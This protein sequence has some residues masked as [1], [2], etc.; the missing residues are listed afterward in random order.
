MEGTECV[1][2][3]M[4]VGIGGSAGS[5]EPIESFISNMPAKSGLAFAVALH[6]AADQAE[7]M[8]D[9]LGRMTSMPVRCIDENGAFTPD[10]ISLVRFAGDQNGSPTRIDRFFTRLAERHGNSAIAIILSGSGD[11]GTAGALRVAK[12]G[13]SVLVQA[14]DSAPYPEM[15]RNVLQFCPEAQPLVPEKL[16]ARVL[17]L[18]RVVPI[19]SADDEFTDQILA[20]LRVVKSR[21][22]NDFSA[23]KPS[24]ALRR[25]DRRMKANNFNDLNLYISFLE[26]N[27]EEAQ[28]LSQ[29]FCIGVT[30]FFRDP[31]AFE[32]LRRDIIPNMFAD[33]LPNDP[34]RIWDTCCSTGEETYSLAMLLQQYIE[35]HGPDATAKLF[36]TDLDEL[37][38]ARARSGIYPESSVSEIGE[39]RLKKF[40]TKLTSGYQV[41]KSLRE[42]IIFAHHNLIKDPP[43]SRLDMVVC[44]NFFI[45]LKPELQ[46]R[47]I[48]L[49]HSMLRPGG[50][51]FMGN[52][53]SLGS[54]T[55]LF[56]PIDKRWRIFQRREA[57]RQAIEGIPVS[58]HFQILSRA[59]Q[60]TF[61][62][63]V[64]EPS[65]GEMAR[66][67]LVDRFAPPAIVVN[68]RYEVVHIA[69]PVSHILEVPT[70]D[71][72]RDLFRMVREEVK[73]ALRA[74]IHKA[75]K[76]NERVVFRGHNMMVGGQL[77]E[78]EVSAEPLESKG[79][80]PRMA[81]VTLQPML[82]VSRIGKEKAENGEASDETRKDELI[83][84]LEEQLRISQEELNATIEQLANSND[85]M[86]STNE[87]LMSVNEEFQSTNEELETSKEELQTLNE[88]LITLNTELQRKVEALD[89]ANNDIEN[90]LNGTQIATLFLDCALRVKRF[91][92]TA[93]E[94]FNLIAADIGR[95]FEH[96]TGSISHVNISEDA[97][98]VI[99]TDSPIERA[100]TNAA[101]DRHYLMRL[102]PYRTSNGKVEGVVATFVDFTER[103]HMEDS[104][105]ELAQ[106]LDL[107]PVLVRDL[108]GRIILWNT[109]ARLLYGFS[110]DEALGQVS[111]QLLGT[112]FPEP[113]ENIRKQLH[114]Q[115]GWSGELI[116][117]GRN[118]RPVAVL[119]QWVLYRDLEGRPVRVLEIN[120]DVSELKRLEEQYRTLF[121][122]MADGMVVLQRREDEVKG[123]AG[124]KIQ[125]VNASFERT[126]GMRTDQILGKS[127]GELLPG[128]E[129]ACGEVFKKLLENNE[130]GR[131]AY[132]NQQTAKH[133]E[134]SVFQPLAGQLAMIFHDRTK[135][136]LA[137]AAQGKMEHEL[138][139]AQKMESLG[140]LAGGIAHDFNNILSVILGYA[141]L[142]KS[143]G[144]QDEEYAKWIN[145]ILV[146]ANNAKD[147]IRQI[148]VFSRQSTA[149][150]KPFRIGP[151]ID[152][153]IA[154]LRPSIRQTITVEVQVDE[155]CGAILGNPAQVRRVVV[156]LCTNA[157]HSMEETGGCLRVEVK[158]VA[159]TSHRAMLPGEYIEVAVNDTGVGMQAEVVEKI[160]DPYFTTKEI[161]RGSGMGLAIAHGIVKAHGGGIV[162]ESIPGRG[163][164]FRVYF[165]VIQ[166]T[167]S[168][169]EILPEI[170]GGDER[171]LLVDDDRLVGQIGREQLEKLGY[172]VTV[173]HGGE[174]ALACFTE[175][176]QMCDVVISDQVMPGLTGTE[177]AKRLLAVRPELPIILCTGHSQLADEM[178]VKALGIRALVY[179][180]LDQAGMA[181]LV[182]EVLDEQNPEEGSEKR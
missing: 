72:T 7:G 159:F 128:I 47:L 31:E 150:V 4:V 85:S 164:A 33:R 157:C 32:I 54:L 5:L 94:V 134:I 97:R 141:D 36:A 10:T 163:S 43:F 119:S 60:G 122:Q 40:F 118:G 45:Y 69:T 22:G 15:P 25:I 145:Y 2:T 83:R 124:L 28:A 37:A 143:H 51:L 20:I 63:E 24:T 71:P 106:V 39:Q 175:N 179:K 56:T 73:P 38:I 75:I 55:E 155:R 131:F 14:P 180:P 89:A 149:D 18:A 79:A 8:V 91:T 29:D 87:E 86:V 110:Q 120:T 107:A 177:L 96:I 58:G 130:C 144:P 27:L 101:G 42:M 92:P 19:S 139:Q 181:N 158:P 12:A 80:G 161:G 129:L 147:L 41:A 74:S 117:H 82:Q 170:P 160:F 169:Q 168:E 140:V 113:L 156:N 126:I 125:A 172:Q 1:E 49:F 44:R 23:Y 53:E 34:V 57:N 77:V 3:Q 65:P 148:L 11:D 50:Y 9:F 17:E 62:P 135:A 30:V 182:R 102:L 81:L 132:H 176:P 98:T 111:H 90:L 153:T 64:A 84:N 138:R 121:A 16:A 154:M 95:P 152:E 59:T 137:E 108:E 165:P 146:A 70:G 109:G 66:K 35:D 68:E 52:S 178:S 21:T 61:R 13:G 136:V 78:V 167:A 99:D 46:K 76:K 103:R 100:V 48:T 166:E 151:L 133:F 123:L 104:L 105:R 162:V 116:H 114:L 171:I 26:D 142:F 88:E 6:V 174:E 115:G 112:V 93:T 127:L 173:C 67:L